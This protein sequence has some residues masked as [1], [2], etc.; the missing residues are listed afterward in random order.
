VLVVP[1]M[2]ETPVSSGGQCQAAAV[3]SCTSCF[4][5]TVGQLAAASSRLAKRASQKRVASEPADSIL[6]R[7]TCSPP[8]RH[9]WGTSGAPVPNQ[10][11]PVRKGCPQNNTDIIR[12][13]DPNPTVTVPTKLPQRLQGPPL[14]PRYCRLRRHSSNASHNPLRLR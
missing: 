5:Q 11:P 13:L 4:A 7:W 8:V 10:E 6:N 2:A 12:V 1:K 9:R 3:T 14:G